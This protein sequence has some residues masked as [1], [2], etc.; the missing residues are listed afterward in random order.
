M[1]A[2]FPKEYISFLQKYNGGIPKQN[3]VTSEKAPD[4]ILTCFF[5]TD[6]EPIYDLFSCLKVYKGRIPNGCVPIARDA[7]GN[8]VVLN[9]SNNKY[10]YVF[11]W[12]HEEELMYEETGMDLDDLYFIAPSFNEFLNMIRP[13]NVEENNNELSEYKVKEVW[14]DPDFLKELKDNE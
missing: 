8:L 7:G 11:F 13:Y 2:T 9:L 3:V 12:D 10:G 1:G 6:L 14:I 5:G 4:F